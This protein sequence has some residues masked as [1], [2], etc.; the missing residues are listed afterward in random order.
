MSKRDREVT[1]VTCD[2]K[3]IG[4]FPATE[5]EAK[6]HLKEPFDPASNILSVHVRERK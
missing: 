4:P 5:A 3:R 2:G 1:K 6:E